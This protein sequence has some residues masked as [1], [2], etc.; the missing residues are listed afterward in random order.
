MLLLP[1]EFRLMDQM[2]LFLHVF[3]FHAMS[4]VGRRPNLTHLV[5]NIPIR[6]IKDTLEVIC[7]QL[8][9]KGL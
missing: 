3:P 7:T 5:S 8:T 9:R 2:F 1:M 6:H 4:L